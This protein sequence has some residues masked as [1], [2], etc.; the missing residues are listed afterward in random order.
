M[1]DPEAKRAGMKGVQIE[2]VLKLAHGKS[3]D[4]KL[5]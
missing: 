5:F 1:Q 3:F 4:S 2:E